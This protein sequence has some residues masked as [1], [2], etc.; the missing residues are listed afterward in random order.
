MLSFAETFQNKSK[1]IGRRMFIL[2]SLKIAVFCGIISRLFYLQISKITLHVL[3][4]LNVAGV[5]L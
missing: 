3:N 1:L 4:N 2:S 5:F